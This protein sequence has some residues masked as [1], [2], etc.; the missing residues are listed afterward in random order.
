MN[1]KL[2]SEELPPCELPVWLYDAE[3]KLGPYI[4]CRPDDQ[5]AD[6]W[7]WARCYDSHWW[8][9]KEQRWQAS[10]ADEDDDKPTHWMPLPYPPNEIRK[11]TAGRGAERIDP[12]INAVLAVAECAAELTKPHNRH[13]LEIRDC[14]RCLAEEALPKLVKAM[15]PNAQ[16]QRP[17]GA[18]FA[19]PPGSA[20]EKP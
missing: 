12:H 5:D 10:D 14:K 11:W 6:G 18:R 15:M 16:G 13:G 2:T 19:E 20:L 8:D 7:L 3:K 17:S 9:E 4:G 1:W